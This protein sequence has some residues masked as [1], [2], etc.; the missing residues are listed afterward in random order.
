MSDREAWADLESTYPLEPEN[1]KAGFYG[2]KGSL[3]KFGNRL[4]DKEQKTKEEPRRIFIREDGCI[5]V[6]LKGD[7]EKV[8]DAYL[9]CQSLLHLSDEQ[10]REFQRRNYDTLKEMGS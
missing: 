7:Q 6:V 8:S 4:E 10:V 1:N 3:L 2:S 9:C 5:G